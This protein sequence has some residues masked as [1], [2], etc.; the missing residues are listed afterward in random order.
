MKLVLV[1]EDNPD[2]AEV[3]RT[4]LVAAGYSVLVAAD[5]EIALAFLANERPSAILADFTLPRLSGGELGLALRAIPGFADIP[6]VIASGH[7][8]SMVRE[9]FADYDAF[10]PKPISPEVIVPLVA[11]LTRYGR[12]AQK[13]L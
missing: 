1:V 4:I 10:L 11:H 5:G 6:I 7:S 8:Q 13:S 3:L 9:A 12:P 2:V